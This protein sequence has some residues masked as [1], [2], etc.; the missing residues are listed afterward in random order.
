MTDT[1]TTHVGAVKF[2]NGHF[3]FIIPDDGSKEMF[4]HVSAVGR[5]GLRELKA[6][7]RVSYTAETDKKSGRQC[8]ENLKLLD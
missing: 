6:N 7:E 5:A 3:G 1:T 2:F 8:A 4:V